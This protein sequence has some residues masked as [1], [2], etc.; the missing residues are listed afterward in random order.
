M[1][2][3][4]FLEIIFAARYDEEEGSNNNNINAFKFSSSSQGQMYFFH[5]KHYGSSWAAVSMH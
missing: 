4:H 1:Y 2:C 3:L 5:K